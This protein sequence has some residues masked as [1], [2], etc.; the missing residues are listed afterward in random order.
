M[1]NLGLYAII[2]LGMRKLIIISDWASDTLAVTEVKLAI[3]GFLDKKEIV[4]SDIVISQPSTIHTGFLL[5]QLVNTTQRYGD[6]EETVFFINTDPRIQTEKGVRLAEGAKGLIVKL[7]SG[8]YIT[9]P[10]AGF[11]YSF[12]KD[13]I[14]VAYHY[15]PLDKGSQFRSRD[16]YARIISALLEYQED[17]LELEQID[18]NIIPEI[19]GKFVAHID[20]YG[21]IKTTITHEDLKS[22][23]H[24]NDQI[25]IQINGVKKKAL[26]TD[27]LFGQEPGKLVIYPGSSG[28]PDNP[29]I[30]IAVRLNFDKSELVNAREIFKNP[31]IGSEIKIQ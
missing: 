18:K 10:N 1:H 14:Q 7:T 15:P 17:S 30:E 23:Y 2:T 3:E 27:N 25:Q 12:I 22:R 31:R 19:R 5:M 26:Y 21:N 28:S 9:G 4:N 13:K 16:N 11:C 24:Y 20:N 29:F 6:P 8:I